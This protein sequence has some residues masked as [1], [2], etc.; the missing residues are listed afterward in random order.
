MCLAASPCCMALA[1]GTRDVAVGGGSGGR[2]KTRHSCKKQGPGVGER[3]APCSPAAPQR[4]EG[5][6]FTATP[7]T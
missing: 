4:R 1:G 6:T 3:L 5:W 7:P 2:Q